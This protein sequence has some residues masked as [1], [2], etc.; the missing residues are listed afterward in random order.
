MMESKLKTLYIDIMTQSFY[1]TEHKVK[2]LSN[3]ESFLVEEEAR[4]IRQDKHCKCL[5]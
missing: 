2:V 5:E 1:P 4:M 3:V